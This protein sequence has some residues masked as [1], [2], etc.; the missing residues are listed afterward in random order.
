VGLGPAPGTVSVSDPA[1]PP[2]M[3]VMF[4]LWLIGGRRMLAVDVGAAR[5]EGAATLEE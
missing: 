5:S 4:P 2:M 1:N 3:R